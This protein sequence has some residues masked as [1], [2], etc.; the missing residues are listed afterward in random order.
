[1]LNSKATKRSLFWI[2]Y[3]TI[4]STA[5]RSK[6]ELT[7]QRIIA[8]SARVFNAKGYSSASMSDIMSVTKLQK[9]GIYRYFKSKDDLSLAA[10]DFAYNRFRQR[11]KEEVFREPHA[12][13]RLTNI[14]NLHGSLLDD[15]YLEGGC[16][17][18][19][20]AI[21]AD[22]THTNLKAKAQFAM[23]EWRNTVHAIIKKGVARK[24]L[25]ETDPDQ[26]ATV[27]IASLE[28]AVMLAKLYS[29][30]SY[31]SKIIQ[32]LDSHIDSFS[33]YLRSKQP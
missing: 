3:K 23:D 7:R 12:A 8:E 1:M 17:I 26:L 27:I 16:P 18:L 25:K 22:S 30:N 24:E 5:I 10:F 32:H 15:P 6:G 21:E 11:Y 31:I 14:L 29:D 20:T 9:G 4:V 2:G 28:G 13:K 33:L 19:N